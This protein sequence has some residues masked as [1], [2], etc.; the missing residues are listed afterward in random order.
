M[1]EPERL[2]RLNRLS[3]RAEAAFRTT[4]LEPYLVPLNREAER[5]RFL[6]SSAIG[7]PYDPRLE[8][9]PLPEDFEEPLQHLRSILQS[10]EEHWE[11]L[12][13]QD[14]D[15]AM[16]IVA[17]A[18]SHDSS[19]ITA[20]TIARYGRPQAD[21]LDLAHKQLAEHKR[22]NEFQRTLDAELVATM[23]RDRLTAL[24]LGGWTVDVTIEMNARLSVES[25]S[26]I[27]R[28]RANALFAPVEI[29]RLLIHEIGTHVFR[30]IN[31]ARQPLRLLR[32]GLHSY[33]ATEE[34][35]AAW[36][37]ATLA[38]PA[39]SAVRTYAL[40]IVC[41]DLCLRCGFAEAFEA[42]RP[43]ATPE[44]LFDTIARAKRGFA[45]T[46]RPGAHVKDHV[47][48]TG[49]LTVTRHLN[50][51]PADHELLMVGKVSVEDL[52]VLKTMRDQGMVREPKFLPE[53]LLAL[54][55]IWRGND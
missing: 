51:W 28:V 20:A 47:Y 38:T 27:L 10:G 45:D 1:I 26:S 2:E 35:L 48:Y 18:R 31:G 39:A 8:F 55:S 44:E 17:A 12:L 46:S 40:R 29:E 50:L 33:L 22:A 53:H 32:L 14:V 24:G 52:P 43:Y 19:A 23:I 7:R 4:R 11:T 36:H 13:A 3:D 9:Q 16:E 6:D 42:L 34:G 49:L 41:C 21:A 15:E 5:R 54:G 37:E 25:A 30:G